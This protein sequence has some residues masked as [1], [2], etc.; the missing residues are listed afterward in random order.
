MNK[1]KLILLVFFVIIFYSCE[2]DNQIT[3][4]VL[5]PDQPEYTDIDLNGYGCSND[6]LC[7]HIGDLYLDF[8]SDSSY[9]Q[10]FYKF[11]AYHL[12]GG[13]HNQATDVL[14]FNSYNSVYYIPSTSI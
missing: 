8:L 14:D 5:E 12:S 11:N 10:K 9:S 7:S 2:D 4:E 13:A 6:Y 3:G 1:L